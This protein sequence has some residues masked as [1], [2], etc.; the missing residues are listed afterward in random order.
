M[1]AAIVGMVPDILGVGELF[2]YDRLDYWAASIRAL[3][4]HELFG[5]GFGGRSAANVPSNLH[6]GYIFVLLTRGIIGLAAQI[7]LLGLAYR[8]S[9]FNLTDLTAATSLSMLT[10][11]LVVTFFE[12]VILFG[13]GGLP[14]LATL[15]VGFAIQPKPIRNSTNRG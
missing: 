4:G 6:N 8:H 9:I 14:V 7:T 1:I 11:V 3:D 13:F 12:S 15:V 2:L 5:I 10:M